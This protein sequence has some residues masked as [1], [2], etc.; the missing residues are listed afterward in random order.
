MYGEIGKM[1]LMII[2]VR[3]LSLGVSVINGIISAKV[4]ADVVYDLKK[5][6]FSTIG[7][8]SMKFFS[9][10]QT[11]GLMTQ[12][13]NDATTIYW[14]F[15]DG[16]P[17]LI[18]N[19]VQLIAVFIVMLTINPLL[20]LYTFITVPVFFLIYKV[21]FRL[22]EKL[23]ARSYSKTRSLNSLVS[24]VLQRHARREIVLT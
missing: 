15:V 10:R 2:G 7:K 19:T 21:V 5:T 22:F 9:S 12:I 20:T 13:N 18:T 24:D 8:L 23:H 17:F 14:F 6:I 1:L 3:L 16:L 11:G 4:A